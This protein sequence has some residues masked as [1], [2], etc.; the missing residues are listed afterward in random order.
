[1]GVSSISSSLPS[2][3][4]AEVE[5]SRAES[6]RVRRWVSRSIAQIGHRRQSRYRPRAKSRAAIIC[7]SRRRSMVN[8]AE[9][10]AVVEQTTSSTYQILRMMSNRPLRS[11]IVVRVPSRRAGWRMRDCSFFGDP[12]RSDHRF[13][14]HWQALAKS[15]DRHATLVEVS[16]RVW[17]KITVPCARPRSKHM[18]WINLNQLIS[19]WCCTS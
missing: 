19:S 16:S 9:S 12:A 8:H 2:W 10:T 15:A 14:R 18:P 5:L 3:H 1:V 7:S 17:S 6:F 13:L 11:H 4:I